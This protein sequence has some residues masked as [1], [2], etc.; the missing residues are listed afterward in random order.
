MYHRFHSQTE[1]TRQC[2]H[3]RRYYRPVSLDAAAS[4]L[5]SGD[6]FESNAIAVTIDDGYQDFADIAYPVFSHYEIPV[7]VYLVSD[8]IAG[9]LW[10]WWDRIEYA[11]LHSP[12]R[13]F[14]IT[15]PDGREFSFSFAGQSNRP[16]AAH[17]VAEACVPLNHEDRCSVIDSLPHL[18]DI[19]VPDQAPPDFRAMSWDTVRQLSSRGVT[20][21]AHTQTH[22]ILSSLG[23]DA[24]VEREIV[25]SRRDIEQQLS[26]QVL[27][28]CYPN[29]KDED[30]G[31][32]SLHVLEKEGFRT[33]VTTEPGV[34]THHANALRL[35]RI[36]V[37][38][39]MPFNGFKRSAAAFRV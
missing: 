29:G 16:E 11:F 30:I 38:D 15:L 8:F 6:P 17:K 26:M 14:S 36:G 3:L 37:E 31:A 32:Y 23:G 33:A 19:D 5:I 25:Q 24:D 4:S 2:E 27:H 7:T 12:R 35:L 22:P 9:R 10:L 34:N 28:F 18:L 1:L 20:F 13:Q 39:D 21:G